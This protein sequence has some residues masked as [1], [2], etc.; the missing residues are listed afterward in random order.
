MAKM[1][2]GQYEWLEESGYVCY[3]LSLHTSMHSFITLIIQYKTIDQ[4]HHSV[5]SNQS[6][7]LSHLIY[8]K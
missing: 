6:Q 3:K 7:V 5:H 8:R 2:V 1:L 4:N